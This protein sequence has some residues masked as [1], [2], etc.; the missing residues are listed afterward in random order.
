MSSHLPPKFWVI[1]PAA[2]IGSRMQ[3]DKPK[4]YLQIENKTILEHTLCCFLDHPAFDEVHVGLSQ[5]DTYFEKYG[6]NLKEGV[7]VFQGG[8]ERADTVLNG[9]A[10]ISDTAKDRDWVWVHDAARPC[11]SKEEIDLLI[12]ELKQVDSG[13]VLGVPVSDTLKRIVS[14][15][16]TKGLP[17]IKETIDRAGL[18]RAMTP[19]IFS[20]ADLRYALKY[21]DDGGLIVTD[22]AS[23]LEIVGRSAF[24]VHGFEQNVKVTLPADLVKVKEYLVGNKRPQRSINQGRHTGQDESKLKNNTLRFPRIGTGFDVHAFG[25]GKFVIL[26]GVKIPHEKGL[27]AHSDGDVLLHAIMDALLGA[28]ALGDI[29]KHFPDTDEKWQG[30]NSRTLLKSVV[31]LIDE[32]GYQIGNIDSTIIAQTPK[33]APYI[34]QMQANIAEDVQVDSA[35]VSVKATTTE[36]LGFTGRKEGVA[37]QASVI[38]VPVFS[39]VNLS[40]VSQ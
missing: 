16:D 4:Q 25:E 13:L 11:L 28:L 8:K 22:E 40:G 20:Y 38:L 3:A 18:W 10:F 30:A 5:Q 29:G 21:C 14:G 32:Q 26:G 27:I 31:S 9:L 15:E 23:A 19:Q 37:C 2:G 36:K 1:I 7:K 17:K 34:R 12:E 6:L 35:C 39:S 33:M 24:M